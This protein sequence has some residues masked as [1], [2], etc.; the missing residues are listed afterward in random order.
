MTPATITRL[1][2][3][4]RT[5][6]ICPALALAA[7][8]FAV[9]GCGSGD[10]GTIPTQDAETL[11]QGLDEVQASVEDGDC[12]AAQT[13]ISQLNG[14]VYALPKEVGTETK[15]DLRKLVQ[16]LAEMV[17]EP[18]QCPDPDPGA[19]G[20]AGFVP[21]EP[22]VTEEPAITPQ[23]PD[24]GAPPEQSDQE[25]NGLPGTPGNPNQGG[26]SSGGVGG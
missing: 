17:Q 23:E 24:P 9:A 5:R 26:G 1:A 14:A 19:S 4:L 7:A 16:N 21:S 6:R 11:L 2:A 15:E 18:D 22:E 8:L 20:E 25:G 10:G 3:V 12:S 13:N